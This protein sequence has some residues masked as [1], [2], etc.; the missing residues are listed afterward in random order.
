MASNEDLLAPLRAAVKEQVMTLHYKYN[1]RVLCVGLGRQ[2]E[3]VKG[4]KTAK[5]R[6]Q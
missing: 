4:R 2:C 5:D 3:T 6:D 1:S